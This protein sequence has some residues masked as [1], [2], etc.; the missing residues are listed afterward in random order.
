MRDQQPWR[1]IAWGQGKGRAR[2]LDILIAECANGGAC[3]GG[4]AGA[5]IA[6]EEDEAANLQSER[7]QLCQSRDASLIKIAL[8]HQRHASAARAVCCCAKPVPASGKRT[9]TRV[10]RPGSDSSDM[11]PPCSSTRLLTTDRPKPTPRC[12]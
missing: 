8:P 5:E 11:V 10:P 2:H 4:L 6:L 1:G 3:Q 9:V 12:L 7:Q